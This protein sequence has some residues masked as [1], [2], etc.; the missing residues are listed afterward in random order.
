ME[1]GIIVI[2]KIVTTL[3]FLIS[4][5]Y[6]IKTYFLTRDK[7]GVW[8]YITLALGVAFILG[9]VRTIKEFIPLVEFEVIKIQLIPLV[10]AFFLAAACTLRR[11]KELP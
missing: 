9:S 7:S 8:F 3:F 5:I 11:E 4:F 2:I 6:S 1:V 10:I